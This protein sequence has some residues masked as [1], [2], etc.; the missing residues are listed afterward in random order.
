VAGGVMGDPGFLCPVCETWWA[1]VHYARPNNP[2]NKIHEG[3]PCPT[4][5]VKGC[6]GVLVFASYAGSGRYIVKDF[7]GSAT[8]NG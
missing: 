5:W 4:Q 1:A 8:A 7:A 3:M 6:Q 2:K